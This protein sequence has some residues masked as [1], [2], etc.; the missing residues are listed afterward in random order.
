[1][2]H[3]LG[4]GFFEASYSTPNM[5]EAGV[6]AEK[7][8]FSSVLIGDHLLDL[9]GVVSVDPWSVLSF[10]GARTKKIRLT[11]HVTD[12]LRTHPA[13]V[14]HIAATLDELTDGRVTIGLGAG[15][16]MNL[17]PFGIEFDPDPKE[18]IARLRE[19][20]QVIRALLESSKE[21][22]VTFEG[23]Y[24]HLKDAWMQQRPAQRHLP[25][26]IGALGSKRTLRLIGELGDEWLPAYNTL[27]LFRERIGIIKAA[28]SGAGRNS[29]SIEYYASILAVI[30]KDKTVI[31]KAV[32]AYRGSIL[33]LAPRRVASMG[34]GRSRIKVDLGY[35]YQ[36]VIPDDPVIGKMDGAVKKVPDDVVE[37]FMVIGGADELTEV[38][39]AYQR[40]GATSVLIWDMVAEGLMNSLPLAVKNM[41]LINEKVMPH[42]A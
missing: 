2:K 36:Q 18:R 5:V 31:G 22:K 7:Y 21:K 8:G 34:G 28:A 3:K 40:A 23:R 20:I 42:F 4:F 24:Y 10:I 1:M 9:S 27:D 19:G 32:D 13:K 26:G 15:E 6:A 37:K 41:K 16:S 14:A 39:S 17:V 35:D 11:T 29:D 12:V 30:S 33:S 25:I 38:I